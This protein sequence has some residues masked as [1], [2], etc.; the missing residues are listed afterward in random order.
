MY[1]ELTALQPSE[2]KPVPASEESKPIETIGLQSSEKDLGENTEARLNIVRT[3]DVEGG[4]D[5]LLKHFVNKKTEKATTKVFKKTEVK[6]TSLFLRYNKLT[7][8]QGLPEVL[9]QILPN[10]WQQLVWVD[11]SHNRLTTVSK[12]LQLLPH[13][14]NL[15]LHVNFI[16]A[17]KEF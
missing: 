15:Y 7:A 8:L 6:T 16:F 17:F 13:L 12:E 9:Q 5:D 10:K 3:I 11:L 2:S 4:K 14:K 1:A